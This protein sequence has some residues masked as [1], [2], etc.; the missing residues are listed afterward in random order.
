[1]ILSL[2]NIYKNTYTVVQNWQFCSSVCDVVILLSAVQ[3]FTDT[4]AIYL[5]NACVGKSNFTYALLRSGITD[6]KAKNHRVSKVLSVN[7]ISIG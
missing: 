2:N 7:V 3:I 5:I 6:M 1:M 4:L